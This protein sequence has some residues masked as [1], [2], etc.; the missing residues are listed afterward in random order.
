MRIYSSLFM[1]F[2]L[3]LS[4]SCYAAS[5]ITPIHSIKEVEHQIRIHAKNSLVLFDIDDTLMIAV[6]KVLRNANIG[7][8]NEF[9]QVL[10]QEIQAEFLVNEMFQAGQFKLMEEEYARLIEALIPIAH[11]VY[12]FTK[13]STGAFIMETTGEDWVFQKLLELDVIFTQS[14]FASPNFAHGI[15]FSNRMPK[16][17]ALITFL[18]ENNIN[19]STIIMVDDLLDNLESIAASIEQWNATHAQHINFMGFHYKAVELM[20][21]T[22]HIDTVRAQLQHLIQTAEYLSE[23]QVRHAYGIA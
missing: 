5:S 15:L 11:G 14:Y 1:T 4:I 7:L 6:D 8:H 17:P 3:W 18:E 13:R 20:D 23:E 9:V 21:H 16:G 10:R 2:T 22:P 19:V 12:G